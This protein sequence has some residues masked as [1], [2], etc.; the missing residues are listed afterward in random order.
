YNTNGLAANSNN[1]R[2]DAGGAPSTWMSPEPFGTWPAN[3]GPIGGA[4]NDNA[5]M[6]ATF[7]S[8]GPP[9]SNGRLIDV[10][11]L[12]AK[13]NGTND[14]TAAI[15]NAIA[16]LTSGDTLL[17][18]S[19]TYPTTSQLFINVSNVTVDGASCATIRNTSSGTIMVI[20]GS[21]NGNPN[22]S[23]AVALS[24]TANELAT[25]FTTVSSL[26][27]TP[28]DY[29]RLQQGGKDSSTGSGDTGCDVSGCRGEVVQ[30]ASVSGDT[31]TVTT[32]LHDPYNPSVNA[33][34]AQKILG[35][36]NGMTVKN[37][38]LDGNGTNMQGLVIAGVGNSTI[39]GVTVR[40]VQASALRNWGDFN[41]AWSNIAVTG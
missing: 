36:L 26:G 2:Y 23:S 21:G 4:G 5:S 37:I 34:T 32:A 41:V 33:A 10:T 27:V 39:S 20:G 9:V 25:S 18:P 24:A 29:V 35:P 12:G 28:G 14:D 16:T 30:V 3:Y 38:T 7:V 31:V 11:T 19:G 6:Y 13:G 15:K 17:F 1:L 8:S 40:N 22:Y